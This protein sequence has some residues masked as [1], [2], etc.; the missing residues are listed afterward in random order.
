MAWCCLFLGWVAAAHAENWPGWRGPRGDG[1]SAEKD[2]PTTWG[3]DEN[4]RW[5]G[6]LPG[7]GN[8]SP[9]VWGDRVFLTQSLDKKGTERAVMCFDRGDGKLLWQKAI[10][11]RGE[12]P[13]HGTNPYCA[14]TPVTDGERVIASHGSAGVVCY[15]FAGKQLWHRDLGKFVHIW[16]TAASPILH[17]DLVIL[18]C[19][20]G[21]RT[22][23]V[24]LDKKTGNEV[25][26]VDEP[27]GKSGLKGASEWTGSWSTPRIVNIRGQDQLIMSWPNAVK[28]YDPKTGEVIWTCGG[29]TQLVY[30]SPQ[31]T[32]DVVVAMSGFYGAAVAVR[33][34][35]KGDVTDSRRLWRQA[36]KN[37]QRIGSGVI[38]GDYLY[39]A[40]AGPGTVQC[41]ELTTGKDL[42]DSRR[43]GEDCW[44]S[45]VLA[46]GKLYVTDQHG[47]TFILAAQP[48]F[49]QI[50]RN[51][52]GEHT[53]ASLAIS[54]GEIFIRTDQHLWCIGTPKK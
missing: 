2:V 50:R 11:F 1:T 37:P 32:P 33:T 36:Q 35:G 30:T 6:K 19:G 10:P 34:G 5:K 39:M 22:F 8:S 26:K 28:A 7:P 45:V 52:L 38:V 14:A 3:P 16:G 29:L 13:T 20:P 48:K 51:R 23:L 9:I 54:D 24:A 40:N 53:N 12:D 41:F 31:V 44:G 49:E 18:N 46:A 21:E 27:G 47:D 25:W 4:V 43:L 42:W 17:G 15:D